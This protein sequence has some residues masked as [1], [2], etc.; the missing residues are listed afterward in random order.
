M[1]STPTITIR[2]TL[3][4]LIGTADAGSVRFELVNYGSDVPRIVGTCIIGQVEQTVQADGTGAFSIVLWGND[5]ITPANTY[6]NVR[7]SNSAGA[8]LV[9]VPYQFSGVGGFDLST[10]QPFNLSAP[11]ST[12]VITPNAVVTNPTATQ[13]ISV[14]PLAATTFN[15]STG[16]QISGTATSGNVLRGNGTDFVSAKLDYADL[17]G[18]PTGGGFTFSTVTFSATPTFN[19]ATASTFQITLTGDV[20]VPVLSGATAGQMLTFIV[21]QDGIGNHAFN[22]PSNVINGDTISPNAGDRSIQTFIFDGSNA[23][24]IAAMTVN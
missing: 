21:I 3:E 14:F 7:I 10:L 23:Y 11:T 24:P 17:T 20:T 4:N 9:V 1:P 19:A 15:A 13:I 8:E 18:T 16:F 22:W 5:V 2:G 6:Y 12:P